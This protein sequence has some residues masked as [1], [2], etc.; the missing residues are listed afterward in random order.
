MPGYPV[1]RHLLSSASR[2]FRTSRP[3]PP[4]FHVFPACAA[5]FV[6]LVYVL[7]DREPFGCSELGGPPGTTFARRLLRDM[8]HNFNTNTEKKVIWRSIL[9]MNHNQQAGKK[10]LQTSTPDTR[11]DYLPNE[12]KK[13]GR[14]SKQEEKQKEQNNWKQVG[15]RTARENNKNEEKN[16]TANQQLAT[17]QISDEDIQ[18]TL[19]AATILG[20]D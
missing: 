2:G 15:N 17:R 16:K 10:R 8:I 11:T 20:F 18:P 19:G 12:K 3:P 9:L 14:Q 7:P 1:R 4:I 6:F 5:L 13:K